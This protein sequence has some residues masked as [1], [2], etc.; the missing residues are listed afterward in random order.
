MR[1]SV[2]LG[3]IVAALITRSAH[4]D[5][6]LQFDH[7]IAPLLK[8]H[9]VKCH[10]PLK[11]EGQLN[12]STTAGLIR[13]GDTGA[14]VVPHDVDASLIW[15]RITSDEM[16]PESPLSAADKELLRKWIA[17]GTPGLKAGA[18]DD[19]E[20]WSFRPLAA[21]VPK[22]PETNSAN[23]TAV[24]PI[25]QFLLTDLARD[26]LSFLA[27]ADRHTLIRRISL[28]LTGL[29]PTPDAIQDF[30]NDPQPDAYSRMVDRFLASP[31][32]GERYGK[33]WLDAAGYA[34]SNGYFNADTDRPL[35]Y[36]YRDYVIRSFNADKPFHE[37]LREQLAGDEIAHVATRMGES[38]V[39]SGRPDPQRVIE[40]LEATHFL[41][42][43]Q[44]GTGESDGNP[45][46]VRVDRYTVLETTMQ[47]ISTAVLGLTVQCAKCHDH[48]FEPITQRDYY[49]F[50]AILIPA[51]PPEDWKKPNE[52]FV[53]APLPGEHE[54]WEIALRDAEQRSTELHDEL[55]NWVKANR[56]RGAILFADGFDDPPEA[57]ANH[58]SNTAP[59]DDQPGGTAA[60]NLNS[61]EAPA[62][63]IAEG[64]L[65]LIEGGPGG[66]K[67]LSTKQAFDWTPDVIGGSI[68]VTFD[69]IDHHVENSP[70]AERIGY[71]FALHDFNNN[72]PVAG[73][74][75]L[76]DG[77]PSAGTS[78][79]LDYPGSQAKPLGTLGKTG[80]VP[81]RNYGIRITNLGDGKYQLQQL[82]DWQVDEPVLK[83]NEADL[84]NGGFGFEFCCGRSFVVDNV[85]IETFAPHDGNDPLA[86][87]LKELASRRQPLDEAT[88]T[89]TTLQGARP[90]KISWT[91]DV[92]D[93]PP[94][95]HLF[96]RGSLSTP[97]EVVEPAG[98]KV[99]GDFTIAAPHVANASAATPERATSGRRLAL[100]NWLTA[101]DSKPE[102]L[103]ARV[104][105][106]R[107]WQ[108]HFGL[109]LVATT[110][111]FGLSGPVPSNR[112][113]VDWLAAEYVRSGWST[114]QLIR[115]ITHSA[116]YR[117]KSHRSAEAANS[118]VTIDARLQRDPD[119]RRLSRFPIR[120]L[121]AEAIRDSL[122]VASHDFDD[123]MFG[124]YIPTARTANGETIVPEENPAVRRRSI[125]LQ[126]KRTQVHSLLQVFDAPS[127]VFNSTRR[128]RSTMP[129]QSLSLLNSDFVVRRAQHLVK[130]LEEIENS[131]SDRLHR[132]F[133][134]TTGRPPTA[135]D[136]ASTTRFLHDQV[137]EYGAEPD[138]RTRAWTDL[139]QMLLVENAALYVD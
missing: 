70:P 79:T 129:L 42:N 76:I 50:Q 48:K 56:P 85:V 11:H 124:P 22:V 92:V 18:T 86:I 10:G 69:L 119:A 4:C 9:C 12:L 35:A 52:R 110:D 105:V 88:K 21:S 24:N 83:L 128:A 63:T 133:L 98:F 115:L 14:A 31:H 58:W 61:R 43:G 32:F 37:F 46:E 137:E 51:F 62:A 36:R 23:G 57:L 44:D 47:N 72:S 65:Q 123:R 8:R 80:Y 74:N 19:V 99:L 40:L 3:M 100:A 60:V 114:K 126:Q 132:A 101:P 5:E 139:C 53:Y 28:D 29:P 125:Y 13:G 121:D 107:L 109:G 66:D 96:E 134:Q 49:S 54:R 102:A 118:A 55:A 68:Q 34:D 17:A 59:G 20:H 26:G 6:P 81:G 1:I 108:H 91:S 25:D 16:P 45:D 90:G 127:I 111:N 93:Q 135:D 2:L 71:F 33:L 97:G 95:A 78:V 94:V 112:E 67:W 82:V 116:A 77:H 38:V 104:Q 30:L 122:L 84:P 27:E 131:D 103:M 113:L 120:R 73:G 39:L 7:D 89:K 87:F 136:I 106:N 130:S 75:I 15:Q 138:A 41:R 117:Q 64:H